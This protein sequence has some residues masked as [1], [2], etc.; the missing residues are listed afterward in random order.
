M[1]RVG[2]QVG[3][4]CVVAGDGAPFVVYFMVWG[5]EKQLD[6]HWFV[7]D[8]TLQGGIATEEWFSERNRL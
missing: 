7:G 1:R 2:E 8:A 4:R 3:K 5:W 6:R